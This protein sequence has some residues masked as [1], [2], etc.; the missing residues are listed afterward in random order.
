MHKSL[1]FYFLIQRYT[2]N[3]QKNLIAI[4]ES[5]NVQKRVSFIAKHFTTDHEIT[6]G[7]D[8]PR[9]YISTLEIEKKRTSL[10]H[11]R[12]RMDKM[13]ESTYFN[14]FLSVIVWG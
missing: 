13:G 2:L 5:E 10:I 1:Y 14:I 7:L 11:Y 6:I 9:G 3:E 8:I 12:S 4:D